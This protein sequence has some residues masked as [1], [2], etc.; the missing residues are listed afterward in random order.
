LRLNRKKT[1]Q[2]IFRM[3]LTFFNGGPEGIRTLD[4]CDANAALSQLSHEPIKLKDKF[5]SLNHY[6][7]FFVNCQVQIQTKDPSVCL[8]VG[9]QVTTHPLG[10]PLYFEVTLSWR[11]QQRGGRKAKTKTSY[12]PSLLIHILKLL[13]G[14]EGVGG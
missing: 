2:I 11:I 3:V 6:N 13:P 5:K 12:S 10:P 9:I 8:R 1:I 14:R 4:L 7:T